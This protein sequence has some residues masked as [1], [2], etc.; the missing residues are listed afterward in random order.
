MNKR[1]LTLPID[2][3]NLLIKLKHYSVLYVDFPPLMSRGEVD[4]AVMELRQK[5]MSLEGNQDKRYSIF[6]SNQ[7][8]YRNRVYF[9]DNRS[10]YQ[11]FNYLKIALGFPE[12]F[13][14]GLSGSRLNAASQDFL[15][16][17]GNSDE[18][19]SVAIKMCS[20][21]KNPSDYTT[22]F[23]Y[24]LEEKKLKNQIVDLFSLMGD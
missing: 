3:S 6:N 10:P 8:L 16:G 7:I 9:V 24:N 17:L 2:W 1:K 19:K 4:Q 22:H 11:V 15:I 14:H 23:G 20:Y 12:G 21:A 5:L 18:V 13:N